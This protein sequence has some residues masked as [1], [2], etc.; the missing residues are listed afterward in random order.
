MKRDNPFKPVPRGVL[1]NLLEQTAGATASSIKQAQA[2]PGQVADATGTSTALSKVPAI[3]RRTIEEK[4]PPKIV[5]KA[6]EAKKE[7]AKAQKTVLDLSK[8]VM[9]RSVTSSK[10]WRHLFSPSLADQVQR[11][12]PQPDL[13][14]WAVT[15]TLPSRGM[16]LWHSFRASRNR[17]D[18]PAPTP[19][20]INS[21]YCLG[22]GLAAGGPVRGRS[23]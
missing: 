1:D 17:T 14:R 15:C 16:Y 13:D 2:L 19:S 3:L 20:A 18:R 21:N 7:A 5:E 4:A 8:G 12:L 10:V 11:S 6:Q 9:P 23:G 22:C